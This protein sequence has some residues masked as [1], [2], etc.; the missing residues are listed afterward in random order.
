M[1]TRSILA[2]QKGN[3]VRYCFIHW[4]GD[5]HGQTLKEMLDSEIEDLFNKMSPLDDGK[6]LYLSH[7][8]SE[9]Y[10]KGYIDG[11]WK[12]WQKRYKGKKGG[13][14]KSFENIY[15]N[16]Q[17]TAYDP[18]PDDSDPTCNG[19][20]TTRKKSPGKWSDAIIGE[21]LFV[22]CEYIWHY[23]LDTRVITWFNDKNWDKKHQ[24]NRRKRLTP[25]KYDFSYLWNN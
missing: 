17:P 12:D 1:S 13:D 14:R 23:N 16:P 6:G 24:M 5:S 3:R 4:D 21:N 18:M 20:F 7:I 2:L 10:H 9:S 25:K 15:L 22:G 8:E 19:S 11:Q